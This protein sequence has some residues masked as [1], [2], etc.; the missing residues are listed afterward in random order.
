MRGGVQQES[1]QRLICSMSRTE[2]NSLYATTRHYQVEPGFRT[3]RH[4]G[5]D[6]WLSRSQSLDF[7]ATCRHPHQDPHVRTEG[8]GG[9][10]HFIILYPNEIHNRGRESGWNMGKSEVVS[11][12]AAWVK[13]TAK[14]LLNRPHEFSAMCGGI[15]ALQPFL[16][17]DFF[18][19]E[20]PWIPR[21]IELELTVNESRTVS[22][23]SSEHTV[24]SFHH[25]VLR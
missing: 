20:K 10:L 18:G 3:Y 6:D 9:F 8:N 5:E 13:P 19:D 21:A 15:V 2:N 4:S 12:Y 16:Y 22:V 25:S 23:S 1:R 17:H 24:T 11:L 14:A 7:E